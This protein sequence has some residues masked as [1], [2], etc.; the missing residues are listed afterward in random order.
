MAPQPLVIHT[1]SL[2][3]VQQ[4]SSLLGDGVV[5]LEWTHANWWNFLYNLLVQR[6]IFHD[7]PLQ[8]IWCPAHLLEHIPSSMVTE[9]EA[10]RVG[11]S[12]QDI[13][14]NRL[15]DT[16]AKNRIQK[17]ARDIKADIVMKEADVFARQLWLSKCNRFC[18]KPAVNTSCP[19]ETVDQAPVPFT[20]REMCPRWPWDVSSSLYTWHSQVD[21]DVS[22]RA[23]PSLS[24]ANFRTFL[25][26][27][28]SIKWRVGDGYACSVF[29]LAVL[30]FIEGWRFQH[31]V[32]TLCTPQAYATLIRAGLAFAN[33]SRLWWLPCCW[34]KAIKA[35]GRPFPK[36]C[37]WAP[38][39]FCQTLP[40]R[41]WP[42]LSLRVLSNLLRLGTC[43]STRS[44]SDLVVLLVTFLQNAGRLPQTLKS[45]PESK[46]KEAPHRPQ[47][48]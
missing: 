18:K 17:A 41:C 48:A 38:K 8:L 16:V 36:V 21:L 6:R 33:S 32:G 40:S 10:V 19:G 29:E 37:S 26:F 12:R 24:E 2:T 22:F 43:R 47:K 23:T 5:Q 15:A 34:R 1:D 25:R 11:S 28:S 7:S 42:E 44:C 4:F 39:P 31:Q 13:V 14:L 30:A 45:W 35:T 27:C 46:K 20:A 3:I 9:E